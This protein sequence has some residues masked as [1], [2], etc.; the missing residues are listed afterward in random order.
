MRYLLT[1]LMVIFFSQANA[2]SRY[3]MSPGEYTAVFKKVSTGIAYTIGT[4]PSQLGGTGGIGTQGIP[5]EISTTPANKPMAG[6]CSGLHDFGTYSIDSGR[7]FMAGQANNCQL[8]NGTTTGPTTMYEI[9]TDAGGNQFDS[10]GGMTAGWCISAAAPFYAAY[11]W[12][13]AASTYNNAVYIW[14]D[15]STVGLGSCIKPTATFVGGFGS[16]E[17]IQSISAQNSS[18]HC[19]TTDGKLWVLGGTDDYPA[20]TGT[21]STPTTWTQV[22]LPGGQLASFMCKGNSF[23]FVISTTGHLISFG[24]YGWISENKSTNAFTPIT[25]PTQVDS[26][27]PSS[28]FPISQM[29]AAHTAYAILTTTNK[30]F[31]GGSN[32]IGICGTGSTI[33]WPTYTGT[34]GLTPYDW[35]VGMGE[36]VNQ[37]TQIAKNANV[38]WSQIFGG[39]LYSFYFLAEDNN[40]NLYGA[41]RDK[42]GGIP[43]GEIPADTLNA[44]SPSIAADYNMSWNHLWFTSLPDP[45]S[46]TSSIV[47]SCPSCVTGYLTGVPCSYGTDA[48]SR[49]NT[50]LAAHLIITPTANG[51]TW[52]SSTSTT[53]GSHKIMW[54]QSFITQHSGTSIGLGVQGGE[55][56]SVTGISA[57][58]YVLN[59]TI[60]DNSWD[61]AFT[62]A[63]VT[64]GSQTGFYC[65]TVG[66]SDANACTFPAPC[67]SKAHTIAQMVSG[68]TL[69]L[70]CNDVWQTTTYPISGIVITSYGTGNKPK[71]DGSVTL[72]GWT[73]MG[74][75]I[76][77]AYLPNDRA[78]LNCVTLNGNL[79][80]MGRYPDTG[81]LT[82]TGLTSSTLTSSAITTLPY[83]YLNGTVVIRD[84]FS[85]IDTVHI[86]AVGSNTFT[87]ATSPS[88]IGGRGNGFF[89]MNHPNTLLTTT[90]IGSWYN[91]VSVD[92]VQVY[93]GSGGPSGQVVKIAVLDTGIYLNGLSNVTVENVDF[94]YFNQYNIFENGTTNILFDSCKAGHSGNNA[95]TA[96]N[97]AHSTFRYD[98]LKNVNN[99][100]A[101]ATGSSSTYPFMEYC[102]LDSIGMWAGMGQT[103]ASNAYTAW[104][105]GYGFGTY[106]YNTGTNIGFNGFFFAGDSTTVSNNFGQYYCMVKCDGAMYY[107]WNLT[108]PSYTYGIFVDSN[109]AVNSGSPGSGI[110]YNAEDIAFGG[111][112]DAYATKITALWNTFAY[113]STAGIFNHG[114]NNTFEYNNIY[115]NTFAQFFNDEVSSHAITGTIF[116]HN[117]VGFQ[118]TPFSVAFASPN[119]DL[120]TFCSSCDS[121]YVLAP[122]GNVGSF[123]TFSSTDPGTGRSLASWQSDLGYDLHSSVQG[124]ILSFYYS[125]PSARIVLGFNGKDAVGTI[126]PGI[127]NLTPYS[128][129]TL[130]QLP[131]SCIQVP[132]GSKILVQ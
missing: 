4:D 32:E 68:D 66:G 15:G 92:S 40:G 124:G 2:Q 57:G 62:T 45:L 31:T 125:V 97:A 110:V 111:Y 113:N 80:G 13:N 43:D 35:D 81:Y 10:I 33:Y 117:V 120:N 21:N 55:S 74:N 106:R 114:A 63:S 70:K 23:V 3:I 1:I 127:L 71:N 7:V 26:Y 95:V 28:I 108:L 102:L 122:T 100:G 25:T 58:T 93:F 53:D 48:P 39:P 79:T 12:Y 34:N 119:N 88:I 47:A 96:N 118:G 101:Y 52:S 107:T 86:N 8:G 132:V 131:C 105:W 104:C 9:L 85:N 103:G 128:S 60:V 56:G 77:E 11:K 17:V 84:E 115:G 27:F 130:I 18:I 54:S 16:G 123:Y 126:Y 29:V 89:M 91:K 6:V 78:T 73:S 99:N 20:N 98:T 69:Y 14:G 83:S 38:T 46:L 94:D 61:T 36:Y 44:G 65:D 50:N 72:S 5:I 59:D 49:P 51:F 87:L 82:Y 116:K 64:V 67:S 90:R 76:W 19:I 24:E 109:I 42:A 30:L 37:C 41:G 75:G 22:T 121:N 112:W 129:R